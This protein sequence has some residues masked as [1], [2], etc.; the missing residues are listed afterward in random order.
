MFQVSNKF[1]I[2]R[3]KKL[4]PGIVL[5]DFQLKSTAPELPELPEPVELLLTE[6]A[7][8]SPSIKTHAKKLG[9]LEEIEQTF[10]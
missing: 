6:T 1:K 4:R 3:K 5:F 8:E 10:L 7:L 2:T 9:R